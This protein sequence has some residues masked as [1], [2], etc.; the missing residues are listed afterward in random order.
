MS[1]G[2]YQSELL[3]RYRSIID[4]V[5]CGKSKLLVQA[6][7]IELCAVSAHGERSI[8]VAAV[9]LGLTASDWVILSE[10]LAYWISPAAFSI[11]HF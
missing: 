7:S 5:C 4:A 2:E 9:W 10:D 11:L 3:P 6:L 8:P 1:V